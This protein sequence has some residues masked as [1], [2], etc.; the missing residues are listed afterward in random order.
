MR[1]SFIICFSWFGQ[2]MHSQPAWVQLPY[3]R[4]CARLEQ[5][6]AIK[7][8]PPTFACLL[9]L[10]F[11]RVGACA[12][13]MSKNAGEWQARHKP[14]RLVQPDR[15]SVEK[16]PA[17]RASRK[18][19]VVV[20]HSRRQEVHPITYLSLYNNPKSSAPHPAE[21]NPPWARAELRALRRSR[22][23]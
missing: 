6:A 19:R 12:W 8:T 5:L 1:R 21:P 23:I 13:E 9:S 14:D 22:S 20:T 15:K 18:I 2:R 11:Q 3:L 16:L 17:A 10:A 4:S 7:L